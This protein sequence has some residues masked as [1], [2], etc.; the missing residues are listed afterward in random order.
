VGDL[1]RG[2]WACACARGLGKGLPTTT[3]I[4]SGNINVSGEAV[5]LRLCACILNPPSPLT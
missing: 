4:I 5:P 1:I 3:T 2:A